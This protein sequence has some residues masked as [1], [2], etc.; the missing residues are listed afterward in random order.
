MFSL[1][2]LCDTWRGRSY[3]MTWAFL[4]GD[5]VVRSFEALLEPCFAILKPSLEAEYLVC[6]S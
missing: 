6:F 1:I 3:A 4:T 5:E 2:C